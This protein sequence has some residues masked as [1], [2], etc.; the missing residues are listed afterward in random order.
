MTSLDPED[1]DHARALGRTMVDDMLTWLETVRERPVWRSVPQPVL[2]RL[3]EP[4][5]RAGAPLEAVYEAFKRDILA[6]P[7]GNV[8]PRFWGWVMGTGTVSA[9]LA[10]MLASGMNSHLAGYDQ[11]AAVIE[12]L[13]IDWLKTLMGFPAGASG[14]LVSG[15]TAANL[16]GL[17]S[18]RVA[19]AGFDVRAEGL[20]AGPPLT[21]YGSVET[22]NWIV[23]ACETMG[24][25]RRAFRA[26][27][28]DADCRIDVDACHEMIA[29]D[30]AD[31]LK[32]FAIVGNAG[33]VSTGAVD[34]LHA[35]RR[36]A[37]AFG[38]WLHVDGAFGS[39]AAWCDSRELVAGQELADSLAFDLHKWGY[40]PYEVG[41]VLTRDG[42]AQ[43][44][45][46]K[47]ASAG[48]PA[49]LRSAQGGIAVDTT[50]F[51]DR[52][53]QLSRGF[54]ALKVWMALK[55]LGV[56]RIGAAI[57][58]NIDQARRLGAMVDAHPDLERLAPVSLNIVCFR[59]V[60]PCL[61]EDALN[62]LNQD[63]LVAL[64]DRGVAVPSQTVLGGRFAIRVSITNHRSRDED[65]DLLVEAVTQIGSELVAAGAS[66]HTAR[67]APEQS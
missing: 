52:G 35:L 53:L 5:P 43:L 49:Y 3:A 13:V 28:V 47:P 61:D 10:D 48:G 62:R 29:A 27:P 1:W 45:A 16:N 37:D 19:K 38:L 60:A 40:L 63:I 46:F 8:H 7:T 42:Q 14:V 55:E 15:G 31:G 44:D 33:T 6:Y 25:G 65:F 18:A 32:P 30:I 67:T 41:A 66:S 36:L 57:Q 54:R 59:Y 34:D 2:D 4:V 23:K 50:Y 12:R 20:Q 26:A 21:V 24:M 58:A 11:S 9:V 56:D 51:A 17:I 22:H 64:Q 39:L